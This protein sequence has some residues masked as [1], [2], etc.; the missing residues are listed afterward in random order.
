MIFSK[1]SS[2]ELPYRLVGTVPN[3]LPVT[4]YLEL[5]DEFFDWFEGAPLFSFSGGM[6]YI[7][8]DTDLYDDNS[9]ALESFLGGWFSAQKVENNENH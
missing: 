8:V 2:D 7:Y 5:N 6:V 1:S 4:K 3:S 9:L